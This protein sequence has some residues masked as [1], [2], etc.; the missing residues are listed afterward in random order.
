VVFVGS[1]FMADFARG[2]AQAAHKPFVVEVETDAAHS[3]DPAQITLQEILDRYPD[4]EALADIGENDPFLMLYSSGTTG[5]PKGIM[6]THGN[7]L[8][9]CRDMARLGIFS[10]GDT[11]LILLPMFHTNPI[12][13]W[14]F[15]I[16]FCG[17]TVCIRKSFSPA[18]FWPAILDNGVT[19]VMGVPAMYNYVYYSIDPAIVDRSQLKLRW[20]FCGA[21]PLSVDL[22]KGFKERFDV[23]IIE[24]YGLTEGT[25]ISTVNPPGGKR[26]IGSIG[27]A[28]PEQRVAILDE[29]FK[30]PPLGARGEICI[31][32]PNT[33]GQAGPLQDTRIHRVHRTVA[34]EPDRQDSQKGFAKI[35]NLRLPPSIGAP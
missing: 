26:K 6:I 3:E 9:I 13:V 11:M 16:L 25:G 21:A 7:Q 8:S 27:L 5:R 15:P 14:T 23:D 24:G 30:E 10:S 35:R 20:A 18:D 22:I 33:W 12:C 1:D 17:Q 29:A 31:Q 4:D 19:I 32:G 2:L 28:L 34:P